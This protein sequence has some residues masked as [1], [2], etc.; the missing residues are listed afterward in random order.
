MWIFGCVH[1]YKCH[2][3]EREYPF[4]RID[5]RM[6]RQLVPGLVVRLTVIKAKTRPGIEARRKHEFVSRM[7]EGLLFWTFLVLKFCC[8]QKVRTTWIHNYYTKFSV[9]SSPRHPHNQI[10]FTPHV[11]TS[12]H[13]HSFL[14]PKWNSLPPEVIN[15]PSA[16]LLHHLNRT[17]VISI[18]QCNII[19]FCSIFNK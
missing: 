16:P 6:R 19:I 12:S 5:W 10:L 7:K 4:V 2:E 3:S 11:G 9:F 13:K 15:S 1:E 14:I 8:K 18:Q 17:S